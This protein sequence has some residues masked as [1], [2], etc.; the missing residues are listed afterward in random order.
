MKQLAAMA[1]ADVAHFAL[2]GARIERRATASAA[3]DSHLAEHRVASMWLSLSLPFARSPLD[4]AT[5]FRYG[6]AYGSGEATVG[7]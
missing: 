6:F 7:R 5:V 1:N 4:T 3:V 2:N